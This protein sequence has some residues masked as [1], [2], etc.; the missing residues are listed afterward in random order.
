MKT[1]IKN[2]Q[3]LASRRSSDRK[4]NTFEEII[5]IIEDKIKVLRICIVLFCHRKKHVSAVQIFYF[6]FQNLLQASNFCGNETR[7]E[8]KFIQRQTRYSSDVILNR[9][10]SERIVKM[11]IAHVFLKV[12]SSL[13]LFWKQLLN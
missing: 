9:R 13:D 4:K 5:Q 3:V 2:S 1:V 12:Y 8:L 11:G 6:F 10:I 7:S